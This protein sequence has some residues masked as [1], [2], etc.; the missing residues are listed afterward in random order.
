MSF[1]RFLSRWL[2]YM[3][4]FFVAPLIYDSLIIGFTAQYVSG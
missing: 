1:P 3:S 2:Q 4:A